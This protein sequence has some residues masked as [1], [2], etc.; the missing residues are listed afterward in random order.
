MVV[1]VMVRDGWICSASDDAMGLVGRFEQ[2]G[3]CVTANADNDRGVC[4]DKLKAL[5]AGRT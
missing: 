2:A 3:G 1:T 5:A 4:A